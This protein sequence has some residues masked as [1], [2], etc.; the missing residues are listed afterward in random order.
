MPRQISY[1]PQALR[2][3]LLRTF[4]TKGYA[5]TSLVDLEGAT[6]LNRRQLYNGIG[7]KRA[8]FLQA[9]D[10]FAETAGRRFLA[11]LEAPEAGIAEIET[12][13]AT[14]V[15]LSQEEEGRAGCMICST[16]QE[17]I[18]ADPD[19]TRRI[20]AYFD[21]IRAAYANALT[22]AAVRS[23]TT[24]DPDAIPAR[25]D[26][27]LGTHVA[28]CILARAGRPEDQLDRIARQAL[29]GIR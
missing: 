8:M 13:L 29:V 25:A 18:A 19:A 26:A 6:G 22:R 7:D 1:D 2:T 5:E 10:D 15:R 12:L 16:S 28:L 14:F 3:D 11:A 23:E 20:D 24:L 4:W 21:R 27:L 9:M 17:K